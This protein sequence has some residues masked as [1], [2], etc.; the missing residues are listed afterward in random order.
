MGTLVIF[1]AIF[2][3]S[4]CLSTACLMMLDRARRIRRARLVRY[5]AA[6][7]HATAEL[8]RQRLRQ[9][10]SMASSSALRHRKSGVMGLLEQRIREA[11]LSVSA[12]TS[13]LIMACIALII[14]SILVVTTSLAPVL[15]VLVSAG[16]GW[17]LPNAIF[18]L[19]RG[20]R[21]RSF[22]EA[23][24]DCLDVF[25]RGLRAGLPV[26]ESLGLVSHHSTGIAHDEFRRCREEHRMGM[27]FDQALAGMADRL[28]TTEAQF[29]AVATNLQSETGGNL[30][31][32]LENLAN[33]LRERRKLRKKAAALSAEI[34]VSAV[35]LSCLPFAIGLIIAILN[36]TYLHPLLEDPRGRLL[37]LAGLVSLS[38]GIASMYKL[39]RIDA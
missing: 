3:L 32:T 30:V 9:A 17:V 26:G 23:L 18:D 24:P 1:V 5:S 34:R 6:H 4:M 10:A 37:A 20:Q 12:S 13:L 27:P 31:E 25:A 29:I 35:I 38:L 19:L 14:G 8:V 21:V 11:G 22:T 36:P 28:G 7:P 33:L 16:C 15:I 39:S 2:T